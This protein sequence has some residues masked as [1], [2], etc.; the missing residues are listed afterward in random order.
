MAHRPG[1]HPVH[2]NVP[3]L[4]RATVQAKPQPPMGVRPPAPHVQAALAAAAQPR[5]PE[6]PPAP[7]RAPHVQRAVAAV[8]PKAPPV[9]ASVRPVA[10]PVQAPAR[11]APAPKVPSKSVVQ[12]VV[13][14]SMAEMWGTVHQR[15]DPAVIRADSALQAVYNDAAAQL[16]FTDF[17]K[18]VNTKP[19]AGPN[20]GGRT[21]FRIQWDT[22]A[23]LGMDSD[24]FIG[25][26]I[27]ELVHVASARMYRRHGAN[28]PGL[29]FANMNLP[30]GTGTVDASIGMTKNQLDSRG[31]QMK[32]LESNWGDLEKK[33]GA[34]NTSGA[35]TES[36][37]EHLAARI[38]YAQSEP[39]VHNETVLADIM[40]Y[41]RAKGLAGSDTYA[42]AK[43]MLKEANDRR[44]ND[45]SA[46]RGGDPEIRRVAAA[47]K[48]YNVTE[49]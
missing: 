6:A 37:Y 11:T 48:W 32:T 19:C 46:E 33:A 40:Y 41:L 25:A 47:A 27:H 21:P 28:G 13:F 18:T 9:P 3:A 24:Y 39:D 14:R 1:Q 36:I 45:R 17:I 23:N 7:P 5:R 4:P 49:W 10:P 34:E 16:P 12:R 22:A 44:R 26:I 31:R 15:F 8:Q 30:A 20:P 38:R 2:R 43:R 29:E 42:F 35:F